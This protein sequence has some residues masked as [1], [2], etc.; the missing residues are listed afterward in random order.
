MQEDLRTLGTDFPISVCLVDGTDEH[1][2]RPSYSF[3]YNL[4]VVYPRASRFAIVATAQ[5]LGM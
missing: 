1:I 2:N 3:G 5:N 4:P